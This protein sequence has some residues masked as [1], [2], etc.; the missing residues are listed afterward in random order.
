MQIKKIE[1]IVRESK[2]WG[3]VLEPRAKEILSLAGIAVPASVV[4]KVPEDISTVERKLH[5][6]LVAKIVSPRV[7]HKSDVGGVVLNITSAKE[8]ETVLQRFSSIE[9]FSGVIVEEMVKGI[10]LIVGAKNDHQFGPM[11]LLGMGGTGVEI[12][13]DA[14]L[15]MAPITESDVDDMIENL[16]AG[17]LL[18]GYRGSTAINLAAL[19][20][21]L[22][23]FS[24]MTMT[25]EG[26]IESIDLNP[27]ICNAETCVV[28][29]ARI[30]LS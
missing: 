5:Y 11:I 24:R 20:K 3:W 14:S 16:K 8:L 30:M 7:V 18:R 1:T 9:G 17:K 22:M 12:Y 19:K 10:E 23:A 13:G 21:L 6:P 25:L 26:Y 4:I 15:R 2:Q 29:D 28:A 27:V